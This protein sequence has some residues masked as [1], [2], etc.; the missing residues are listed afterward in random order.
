MI[1]Y[2]KGVTWNERRVVLNGLRNYIRNR[3]TKVIDSVRVLKVAE[4]YTA[5]IETFFGLLGIVGQVLG[6]FILYLSAQANI[7]ENS[8]ELGVL[9]ALGLN[10]FDVLMVYV[11][12]AVTLV[13]TS[14]ILG[15]G[16]G[17]SLSTAFI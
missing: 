7:R 10:N 3:F 16:V 17:L 13:I 9:R 6:F 4:Q 14:I 2:P 12:E 15:T 1:R 11:Y 5:Y 8:W